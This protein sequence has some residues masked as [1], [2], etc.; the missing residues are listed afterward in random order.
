MT[1]WKLLTG[2]LCTVMTCT[3]WS[4]RTESARTRSRSCKRSAVV[5][6]CG[7]RK[8]GA[9]ASSVH[10]LVRFAAGWNA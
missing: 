5:A 1:C 10:V 3:G 4:G 8:T 9:A 2:V 6:G 7:L